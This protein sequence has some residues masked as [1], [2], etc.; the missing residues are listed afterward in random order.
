MLFLMDDN[1]Y[2]QCFCTEKYE[3]CVR[4]DKHLSIKVA[5]QG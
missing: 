1:L 3:R 4:L 5:L 2:F